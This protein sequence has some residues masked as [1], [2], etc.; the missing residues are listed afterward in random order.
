MSTAD[1]LKSF[2]NGTEIIVPGSG[3][4]GD[5]TCKGRL[6]AAGFAVNCLSQSTPLHVLQDFSQ[7]KT[8]FEGNSIFETSFGVRSPDS[9]GSQAGVEILMHVSYK[10]PSSADHSVVESCRGCFET[11]RLNCTGAIMERNCK[12]RAAT[13][14]YPMVS[15]L[16]GIAFGLLWNISEDAG[17]LDRLALLFKRR[18]SML[19]QFRTDHRW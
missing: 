12:L 4:K 8:C 16:L 6:Q 11:M 18:E 7:Q 17:K 19:T 13:V 9:W 5:A 1:Y 2:Y 15:A 3:C 10:D 14:Q